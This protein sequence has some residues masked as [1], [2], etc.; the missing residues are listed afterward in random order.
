MGKNV[1]EVGASFVI[2]IHWDMFNYALSNELRL[3]NEKA[4]KPEETLK[5]L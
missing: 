4:H 5:L 2:A 3:T 1:N